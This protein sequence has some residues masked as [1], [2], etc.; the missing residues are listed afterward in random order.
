MRTALPTLLLIAGVCLIVA[1]MAVSPLP[2]LAP[3]I[4]GVAFVAAGLFVDVAEADK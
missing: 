2:W 1:G 3:V 4:A